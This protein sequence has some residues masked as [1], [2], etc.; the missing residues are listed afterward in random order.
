MIIK[1]DTIN[2]LELELQTV[3][4]NALVI[5]DI[6]DVLVVAYDAL[7]HPFNRTH[8]LKELC[9]KNMREHPPINKNR[10]SGFHQLL[11]TVFLNGT[12]KLVDPIFPRLLN[13][14]KNKKINLL[15]LT[16]CE[17]GLFG[18]IEQ[19]ENW[20]L[21]ELEQ[22]NISFHPNI[23]SNHEF[24]LDNIKQKGKALPFFKNGIIFADHYSKGE[25]FLAFLEKI[26]WKPNAVLFIDDLLENLID[27]ESACKKKK[28]A[29]K[30]IHCLIA[31][32]QKR[33]LNVEIALKQIHFLITHG[34][35]VCDSKIFFCK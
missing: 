14:L 5:F 31:H 33:H 11:S 25:A 8:A 27:V 32:N 17:V 34:E 3:D 10:S 13:E 1:A 23:F 26:T 21:S 19:L 7:F 30:G 20:K 6:D 2:E 12:R 22:F 35:W 16:K 29:F 24:Y 4:S 28:I 15:G 9:F 18:K